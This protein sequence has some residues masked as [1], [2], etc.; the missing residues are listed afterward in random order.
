MRTIRIFLLRTLLRWVEKFG[1]ETFPKHP[2]LPSHPPDVRGTWS[3]VISASIPPTQAAVFLLLIILIGTIWTDGKITLRSLSLLSW[4]SI[5][6]PHISLT[7]FPL[8]TYFPLLGILSGTRNNRSFEKF[9]VLNNGMCTEGL[10]LVVVVVVPFSHH[11]PHR[12]SYFCTNCYLSTRKCEM[13]N[14]AIHVGG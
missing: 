7:R 6:A 4:S 8:V 14:D 10:P 13:R 5:Q 1:R 3:F 12:H 2:L 9:Q 11:S